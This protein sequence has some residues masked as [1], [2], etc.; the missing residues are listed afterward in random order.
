[1]WA[2]REAI[3]LQSFILS[4]WPLITQI[5]LGALLF[6]SAWVYLPLLWGALWLPAP[7]RIV[8]DMLQ[9][10]G[11]QPGDK[12]VD[13]GAGDGRIVIAAARRF[14]AH[15]V[16][17][18]I[19]PIRC[20]IANTLIRRLKLRGQARVQCGD[21]FEY[22]LADADVVTVYLWPS[23]NQRLRSRLLKQLR[24]GARIVSYKFPFYGWT[25]LDGPFTHRGD[26]HQR[27]DILVY[28]IGKSEP[29]LLA[30]PRA[31]DERTTPQG[32]L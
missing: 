30:A 6:A 32:E 18:E 14:G 20:A 7:T 12:V 24:P 25:P 23:T 26:G 15:A 21:L 1:L 28:E 11:V 2:P 27:D 8:R 19:D 13:L 22:D 9:A 29:D 3:I 17:V 16:G 4:Y 31:Q 5:V 10:A